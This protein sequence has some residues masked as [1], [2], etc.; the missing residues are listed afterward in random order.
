VIHPTGAYRDIRKLR[1]LC[2]PLTQT[3]LRNAFFRVDEQPAHIK[4][5][6]DDNYG[7]HPTCR[8]MVLFMTWMCIVVRVLLVLTELELVPVSYNCVSGETH[9]SIKGGI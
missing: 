3:E 5:I 4:R 7:V 8:S 6:Y 9:Y 2:H 1:S